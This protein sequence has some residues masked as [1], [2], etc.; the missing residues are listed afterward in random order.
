MPVGN[1]GGIQELV[2]V[3]KAAEGEFECRNLGGVRFVPLIGQEGWK[4]SH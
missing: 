2:K 1:P 4:D 3:T